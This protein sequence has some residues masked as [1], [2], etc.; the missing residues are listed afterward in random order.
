ME[1]QDFPKYH[2]ISEIELSYKP[3]IKL[4]AL[5]QY[6]TSQDLYLILMKFW[7]KKLI[8]FVEQFKVMLARKHRII[9]ICTLS[10]GAVDQTV[11]DPKLVFS[12]ALKTNASSLILVHNH[13][14]GNLKPSRQDFH[15][16]EKMREAGK[17]LDIPITDHL[18]VGSE[19]YYSF[20]AEGV[21]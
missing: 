7:D 15:L 6:Y 17:I 4:S 1:K 12:L 5:P 2:Y 14:S 21:F 18:I 10:T 20:A 3:S 11:V 13:P 9:G 19:G 16:T 8:D